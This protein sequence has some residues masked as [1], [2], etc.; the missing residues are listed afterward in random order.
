LLGTLSENDEECRSLID[1]ILKRNKEYLA[2]LIRPVNPSYESVA[3]RAGGYGIQPHSDLIMQG[4]ENNGYLIDSSVVPYFVSDTNVTR[5]NFT[6]FPDRGNY[7]LNRD[8]SVGNK[9]YRGIF[10]IPIACIKL[11]FIEY[12]ITNIDI[13][14][15][16][17]REARYTKNR[18]KGIPELTDESQISKI[19]RYMKRLRFAR[20]DIYSSPHTMM[21]ITKKYLKRYYSKDI[22]IFFSVNCHPKSMTSTHHESLKT[23]YTWLEREYVHEYKIITFQEASKIIMKD[24][25]G[26][27]L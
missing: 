5:I 16:F 4:L 6:D 24:D 1:K 19:S 20:L 12:G 21:K 26:I 8:Q 9:R 11:N 25:K 2:G 13:L 3:F 27:C 15:S 22:D 14:L 10:E 18:G 23:Y 17:F 7:W